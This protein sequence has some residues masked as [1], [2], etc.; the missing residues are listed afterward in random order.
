M[1]E[2]HRYCTACGGGELGQD[3]RCDHCDVPH[4]F[5]PRCHRCR[6]IY[7]YDGVGP[8]SRRWTLLEHPADG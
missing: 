6:K 2:Q 4:E 5:A 7:A 3:G 8:G 1:K